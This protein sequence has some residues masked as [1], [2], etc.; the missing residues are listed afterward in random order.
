MYFGREIIQFIRGGFS[1]KWISYAVLGLL[2]TLDI[3]TFLFLIWAIFLSP[4][5]PVEPQPLLIA[6]M[7]YLGLIVILGIFVFGHGR[8]RSLQA[9]CLFY[10]CVA[11][12]A[13]TRS[14]MGIMDKEMSIVPWVVVWAVALMMAV[15]QFVSEF[16]ENKNAPSD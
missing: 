16:M 8:L 4:H 13:I 7:A 12:Y 9:V 3:C 11:I 6:G 10:T 2:F 5:L 14:F 15:R 1:T